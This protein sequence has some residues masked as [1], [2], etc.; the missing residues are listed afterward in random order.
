MNIYKLSQLI[1]GKIRNVAL[2]TS[3]L[4]LESI[5]LT[6]DAG[7]TLVELTKDILDKLLLIQEK[8]DADGSFD[9]QYASITSQYLEFTNNSGSLIPQGSVVSIVNDN[10]IALASSNSLAECEG[11]V[12]I[13]SEDIE[14][15][16][17]GKIQV[18]GKSLILAGEGLEVG[19]RVYL[20]DEG[21]A[22]L[23]PPEE[24]G[25]IQYL[26]GNL[27]EKGASEEGGEWTTYDSSIAGF[28]H[29]LC[30]DIFAQVDNIYVAT[31]DGLAVSTDHGTT[32]TTYN[33]SINGFPHNL[34]YGIFAQGDNIYVATNGGIAV[35]TDNGTTWTTYDDSIDGFPHN[36]CRDVF[37]QGDNIYVATNGGLA[38]YIAEEGDNIVL[39]RPELIAKN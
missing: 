29:N 11:L 5:K 38:V 25:K 19:K 16:A 14:D 35:S 34:C 13:A 22:V 12:G 23:S 26:L 4:V 20:G 21:K 32:W 27:I 3:T 8:A 31:N 10:E 37:A 9:S 2:E 17:S 28:P 33:S 6:S 1:G 30:Y 24:A 18:F 7:T 39:F 36:I 15:Q